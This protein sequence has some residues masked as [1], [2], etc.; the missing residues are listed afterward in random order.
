MVDNMLNDKYF[1][2]GNLYL[3]NIIF[4]FDTILQKQSDSHI[5]LILKILIYTTV[6]TNKRDINVTYCIEE[7]LFQMKY[8]LTM[9][10]QHSVR[11]LTVPDTC[12]GQM[13]WQSYKT[14]IG[15]TVLN[16]NNKQ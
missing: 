10:L 12:A 14:H 3:N 5:K 16:Y 15:D 9:D 13:M 2:N 6:T 7:L 4:K 11:C 1:A 8:N